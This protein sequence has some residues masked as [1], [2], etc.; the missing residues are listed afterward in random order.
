MGRPDREIITYAND[1]G[2]DQIVIGS[3]G[4]QGR[5]R[6]LFG[7]VSEK[8]AR[9]FPRSVTIVRPGDTQ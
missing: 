5:S 8:V 6:V 4:R 3:H 9:R 2:F 7:S 1:N